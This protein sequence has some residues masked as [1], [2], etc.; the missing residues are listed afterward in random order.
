MTKKFHFTLR[1]AGN[2]LMNR[3]EHNIMGRYFMLMLK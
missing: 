3:F 2:K 1:N